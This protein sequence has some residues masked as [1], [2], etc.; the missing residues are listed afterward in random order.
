M[1]VSL[2]TAGLRGAPLIR[3]PQQLGVSAPHLL[4]IGHRVWPGWLDEEKMKSRGGGLFTDDM[5]T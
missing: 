2:L 3:G 1:G 5:A 4:R